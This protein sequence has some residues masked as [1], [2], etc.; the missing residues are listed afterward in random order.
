[1]SE[2]TLATRPKPDL[3]AVPAAT[4]TSAVDDQSA[5]QP[6][7]D[8]SVPSPALSD[9]PLPTITK[10]ENMSS[11]RS[12]SGRIRKHTSKMSAI[13]GDYHAS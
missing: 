6:T 10:Y 3:P 7:K 2:I 13:L 4:I 11:G 12:S 1:M 5:T 9:A 8:S